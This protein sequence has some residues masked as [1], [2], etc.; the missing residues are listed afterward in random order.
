LAG[1]L[2]RRLPEPTIKIVAA[3]P[4]TTATASLATPP[5]AKK[6]FIS[7]DGKVIGHQIAT[8]GV[9]AAAPGVPAGKVAIA[10]TPVVARIPAPTTP[11]PAAAVTAGNVSTSQ[12]KVQIVKT[13]DGKIQVS[14]SVSIPVVRSFR[15]VCDSDWFV[16]NEVV[17]CGGL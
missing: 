6:I 12:Q 3:H 10:P 11:Q 1:V 7:R 17:V 16:I 8:T 4:A 15:L 2:G 14:L 5:G 9:V 13:A